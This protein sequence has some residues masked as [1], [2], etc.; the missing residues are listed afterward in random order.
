MMLV[1]QVEFG[2]RRFGRKFRL[3]MGLLLLL[4]AA[5]A[6]ITPQEAFA[7]IMGGEGNS[8][9]ADPGWPRSAAAVFNTKSR[10]AWWEGPPFGGGQWFAEC[11][12]NAKEL[13][14]VLTDFAR[15]DVKS[16]Q[17]ILHDGIGSS[18][19]LN[20]NNEPAEREKARMDWVFMVW[21][22]ANWERLRKLPADINPTDPEDAEKGLP[23]QIDVYT[24]GN[25]R[26][27]DVTVPKDLKIVVQ[28]L[29]A[30]GFILADGIVLEGKVTDLTTMKTVAAK[31]LLQRVEPQKTGGYR[32]TKVA[33]SRADA[34]GH[35]VLKKAPAGGH[36]VLIKADGYVPRIIG[37][38]SLDDQP[39]WRSNPKEEGESARME[40]RETSTTRIRLNSTTSPPAGTSSRAG[41]TLP[42]RMSGRN[43]SQSRRKAARPSRSSSGRSNDGMDETPACSPGTCSHVTGA[44]RG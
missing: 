4:S 25:V 23:S 10:I 2:N 28:R 38:P 31:M 19:W 3:G 7:L 21:Q 9:I 20:P 27:A 34:E 42:R 36:R 44:R 1:S 33:E 29:V 14:A 37:Y 6:A 35:W 17:V 26:W 39:R 22:P 5:I 16:K 12:G 30:H 43:R 15:V 11:R 18:F 8:P 41:P 24:G 13:S 32:Y 40:V